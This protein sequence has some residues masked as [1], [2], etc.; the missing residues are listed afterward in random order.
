MACD[1][2]IGWQSDNQPSRDDVESVLRHF[3]SGAAV[4]TWNNDRFFVW[5]PGHNTNPFQG[6]QP[7]LADPDNEP[8]TRWIEVWL[9]D[10]SLDVLTR[11]HDE[12]TNSLAEGLAA[13]FARYWNGERER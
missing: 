10:D 12:Y 13:A 7:S 6:L 1:R 8:R 5:L 2:F 3:F 4:I 11:E 9:G